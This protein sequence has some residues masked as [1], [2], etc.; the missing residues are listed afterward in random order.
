MTLRISYKT[1]IT[2]KEIA[3]Q[4]EAKSKKVEAEIMKLG[5]NTAEEMKS[6]IKRSKVRPQAGQ[7]TRLEDSINMEIISEGANTIGWGVGNISKMD[8]QAPYWKAVNF[9][10]SHLVGK[11][12]FG[13]FSPGEE[14]PDIGHFREGRFFEQKEF[15]WKMLI[16]NPIQ[17]MNYIERTV[18]WLSGAFSKIENIL[19]R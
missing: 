9:G 7:P 18:H 10:S 14:R 17:P 16:K 12:F 5:V 15:G 6:I 1:N 11:E 2:F 3:K 13:F 8:S 4:I 19:R